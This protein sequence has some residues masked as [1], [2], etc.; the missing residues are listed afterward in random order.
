MSLSSEVN[1]PEAAELSARPSGVAK[2][3]DVPG[4][5]QSPWFIPLFLVAWFGANLVALT[6]SGVSV[7]LLLNEMVPESK[8]QVLAVIVGIGGVVVML[9]TPLAG[10][11][12]DR[13][14]SRWGIRRPF[15]LGGSII[16]SIGIMV[17][18]TAANPVMIGVGWAVAQIGFGAAAA[19]IQALFAD[20]IPTYIRARVSALF[21][22]SSSL[23][24]IV[25]SFLIGS[26]PAGPIWWFG[27]PVLIGL[28]A[29]VGLVLVLRDIVRTERPAPL[30][31]RGLLSSYWVNPIKFPDFAW[32]W[33]CRL[34][35]TMSIVP[36]ATFMLN[37]LIDELKVPS[38]Q[39]ATTVGTVLTVYSVAAL[40]TTMISAWLS[41][42]TGRRK[43]FIWTS[44]L[45]TAIGLS[46][47]IAAHDIP[48]FLIGIAIA[49]MAQGAFISVDV[50]LMTEVLPGKAEAGKDLGVVALSYLLAQVLVPVISVPLLAI[51]GGASNYRAL[52]IAA[53]VMAVLGALCVLPIK[54]VR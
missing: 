24:L 42:R 54:K 19:C 30:D 16:G 49:G 10:R 11:L 6:S 53:V 13:S 9:V 15:I 5:P 27:V 28:L 32:A 33:W 39:A 18:A 46:V 52:F 38:D 3:R 51:G 22:I 25:G 50:A 7:P 41:D 34:L 20:Q 23:A 26:L 43:V 17:I 44:V 45:L 40:L 35:V 37:Y 29:T 36:I 2:V 47:A 48:Q 31:L 14:M 8:N 1:P 12:S 21:G 4:K